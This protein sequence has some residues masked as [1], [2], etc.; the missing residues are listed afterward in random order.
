MSNAK[1]CASPVLFVHVIRQL[2]KYEYSPI[3]LTNLTHAPACNETCTYGYNTL[4]PIQ[5]NIISVNNYREHN[6]YKCLVRHVIDLNSRM[7]G[8]G[9]YDFDMRIDFLPLLQST[10]PSSSI[11]VSPSFSTDGGKLTF[12]SHRGYNVLV[13]RKQ[14]LSDDPC[15]IVTQGYQLLA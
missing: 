15:V 4:V 7:S 11:I 8:N 14:L 1:C 2:S 13:T 3:Y 6:N 10:I 12:T 5:F 9:P